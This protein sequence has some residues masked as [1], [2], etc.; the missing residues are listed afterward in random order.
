MSR[1]AYTCIL[2]LVASI[3]ISSCRCNPKYCEGALDNNCDNLTDGPRRCTSNAQCEEPAAVCDVTGSMTCVQ[4]TPDQAGAAALT[5]SAPARIRACP[6]ARARIRVRSPTS[7][8]GEWVLRPAR[9]ER[10][11]ERC[12]RASPR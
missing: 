1:L 4:C 12:R 7:S 11:A 8:R 5:R 2:L 3:G 9:E 10:R 6:M